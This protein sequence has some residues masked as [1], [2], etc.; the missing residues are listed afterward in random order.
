MHN[1]Q[2]RPWRALY[3]TGR[4][5]ALRSRQ[6]RNVPLCEACEAQGHTT[7][8]TVAHHKDAHH[9]DEATFFASPLESLCK[10]CHD[11]LG[12]EDDSRGYRRGMTGAD[13]F[14]LDARHPFNSGAPMLR[15]TKQRNRG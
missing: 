2:S 8:A 14:P 5:Q 6:L 12:A 15:R 13:G 11:R 10:S 9:G 7:P 3:D 4:W 1:C